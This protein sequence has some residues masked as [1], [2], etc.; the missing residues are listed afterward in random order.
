MYRL[1]DVWEARPDEDDL[2]I[3]GGVDEDGAPVDEAAFEA[4]LAEVEEAKREAGNR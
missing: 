2:F 4:L 3:S 1:A